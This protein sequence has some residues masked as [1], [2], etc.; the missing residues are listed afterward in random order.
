MREPKGSESIFDWDEGKKKKKRT[1]NGLKL[2]CTDVAAL[3]LCWRLA[4]KP[5]NHGITLVLF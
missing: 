1:L 5:Q 3:P 4:S 2:L